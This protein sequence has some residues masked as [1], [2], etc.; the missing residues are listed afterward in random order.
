ML[1][2]PTT[3]EARRSLPSAP[4]TA[5]RVGRGPSRDTGG[6]PDRKPARFSERCVD[7]AVNSDC[8]E[9]RLLRV[10]ARR[11]AMGAAIASTLRADGSL[12]RGTAGALP[13]L[14][15]SPALSIVSSSS[16][17]R[18]EKL[19]R[20]G[21]TSDRA[22]AEGAWRSVE[23]S[24]LEPSDRAES[25][26][27]GLVAIEG[28]DRTMSIRGNSPPSGIVPNRAEMTSPFSSPWSAATGR[29]ITFIDGAFPAGRPATTPRLIGVT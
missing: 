5:S 9:R 23:A 24:W 10:R 22:A 21:G 2:S 13:E 8:A 29:P 7:R 19:E 15:A 4:Q 12:S 18:R 25:N 20:N 17:S 28:G 27:A 16:A 1:V 11:L 26:R 3:S 14:S 6:P